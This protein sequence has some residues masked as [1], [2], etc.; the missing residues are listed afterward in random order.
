MPLDE[1][2]LQI[3]AAQVEVAVFQAQIFLDAGFPLD[4]ERRGLAFG[5][6]AQ[7]CHGNLHVPGRQVRVFRGALPH[8]S[9]RRQ[10]VFG[11]HAGCFPE[12]GPVGLLVEGELH[13]AG[14]VAQVDENQAAEVALAL[15][16][17][18]HG[19]FLPG[20]RAPQGAAVPGP[21]QAVHEFCHQ[22]FLQKSVFSGPF[23]ARGTVRIRPSRPP[24]SR[25]RTAGRSLPSG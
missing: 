1:V 19:H 5:E 12:H 25:R 16:P 24:R 9:S 21:L 3:G 20:V 22:K 7:F 14:A 18:A 23:S 13:N 6:D 10:H 11:A 15:R 2:F 8:G 4:G 17:S